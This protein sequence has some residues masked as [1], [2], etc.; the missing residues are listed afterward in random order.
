MP[1]LGMEPIRKKQI[2][3]SV[4]KCVARD[5]IEKLTLEKTA[6]YA[7]LSKGVVAYYFK[8]KETLLYES[9]Q[10]FLKGYLKIPEEGLD[11]TEGKTN[12]QELLL[13]IGKSVLGLFPNKGVLT[14]DE[15]KK[16]ILQIYSKLTVSDEYK[17]MI[18]E[19]YDEYL[20][21]TINLLAWGVES[22]FFFIRDTRTKGIQ[23]L[24]LLEG[25]LIY[26]IMNFQ[27]DS[28]AQFETYKDFVLNL[29][30]PQFP[31]L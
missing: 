21:V 25:L 10:S 26:S 1:K 22:K 16:V 6:K 14:Q 3:D 27:G 28:E 18:R 19:V 4:L 29:G 30:I 31:R 8:N 2:I 17:K 20:E 9:F 7:E 23:I 13:L 12:P 5:G 11:S 24:A 15:T